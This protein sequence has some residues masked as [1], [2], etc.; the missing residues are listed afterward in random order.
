MS[1][2]AKDLRHTL[3]LLTITSEAIRAAAEQLQVA[4]EALDEDR[5]GLQA[6]VDRLEPDEKTTPLTFP[7]LVAK[8]RRQHG[9][10]R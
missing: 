5:I 9:G 10:D 7:E 4:A 1:S 8:D 3:N 6:I 2:I